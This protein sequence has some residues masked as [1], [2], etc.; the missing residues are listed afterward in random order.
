MDKR[1]LSRTT[2]VAHD[3]PKHTI[4]DE[5]GYTVA[6][7]F[8]ERDAAEIA[9]RWNSYP[10]LVDEVRLSIAAAAGG[11]ADLAAKGAQRLLDELKEPK[12]YQGH[13]VQ[14]MAAFVRQVARM[15]TT[16]EADED[17]GN[18][19]AMNGLIRSARAILNELN[20]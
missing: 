9:R 11:H 3:E 1:T 19:E 2:T 10:R 4:A 17:L 15:K 14:A 8:Q 6:R 12:D 16:D 13:P 5:H 20:P 7:A 18:D